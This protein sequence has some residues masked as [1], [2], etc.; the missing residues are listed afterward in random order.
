MASATSLA[1]DACGLGRKGRLRAGHDADLVIVDG[2]PLTDIR[3]LAAV[4]AVYLNGRAVAQA[5]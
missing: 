1:A 3:A 2:D 5:G 4:S